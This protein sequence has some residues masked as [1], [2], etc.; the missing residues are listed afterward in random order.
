MRARWVGGASEA[1]AEAEAGAARRAVQ[2]GTGR[3]GAWSG[4]VAVAAAGE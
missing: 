4:V 2:T 1:E 3:R